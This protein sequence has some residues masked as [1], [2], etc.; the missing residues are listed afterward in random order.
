[1][2]H[3]SIEQHYVLNMCTTCSETD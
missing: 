1:M 2:Y 3:G